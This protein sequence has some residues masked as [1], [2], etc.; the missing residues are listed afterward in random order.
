MTFCAQVKQE[1]SQ[2]SNRNGCCT[3][4]HL[5]GTLLFAKFFAIDRI[6]IASEHSFVVEHARQ[7][8]LEFGIQAD[9]ITQTKSVG[10][11]SIRITD[12]QTLDRIFFD[13]G[14]TGEEPYIRILKQ[15]FMCDACLA[16][17]IAGC[18]LTGGS[19]TDPSKGY[20]LE[21]LTHKKNLFQ[22]FADILAEQEF[23]PLQT[24]R[25]YA[26]V[27]YFKNS[28]QIEDVLT[29]MGAVNASLELMNTKIYKDI[30]NTVNRRTNCEN[31]NIDKIVDSAS[32][33]KEAIE[34]IYQRKGKGHLSEDLRQIA[35]IRL[36]Y[37]ELP[38]SELGELL[39][40]PL[41]KSGVSHRMRKIREEA[42]R[43]KEQGN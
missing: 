38:L 2:Y 29:L 40:T 13:F 16:S 17:F 12:K 23:S 28:S 43:L 26:K 36:D 20:H 10:G 21:F 4:A 8:L 25:G 37:P 5:Y 24:K 31:A 19:I 1:I 34:Y 14:Y 3:A 22:D 11:H 9:T 35:Q 41:T 7:S 33:D 42:K 18:F 27:L 6:V 39:P 32:R 15:N 30:I